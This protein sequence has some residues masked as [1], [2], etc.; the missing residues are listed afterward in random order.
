MLTQELAGIAMGLDKTRKRVRQRWRRSRSNLGRRLQFRTS[1]GRRLERPYEPPSEQTG[2]RGTPSKFFLLACEA[3]RLAHRLDI[4]A[5]GNRQMIEALSHAPRIWPEA[6]RA[7]FFGQTGD[8][9]CGIS[10]GCLQ[11]IVEVE[12]VGMSER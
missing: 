3:R 2:Y 5:I 12:N 8:E 1:L 7:L 11:L 4:D 6:P 9:C 10:L